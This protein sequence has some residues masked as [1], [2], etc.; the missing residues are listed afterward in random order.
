MAALLHDIGHAPFS[1]TLED[2]F[3]I[4]HTRDDNGTGIASNKIEDIFVQEA[5]K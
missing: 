4:V 3:K 1:H 2:Y 5:K